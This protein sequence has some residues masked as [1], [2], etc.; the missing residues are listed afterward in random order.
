[1]EVLYQQAKK[2]KVVVVVKSN[3][4]KEKRP[5]RLKLTKLQPE[6]TKWQC[7]SLSFL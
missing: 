1:V 7:D 2:R 3:K 6:T 4:N 5:L